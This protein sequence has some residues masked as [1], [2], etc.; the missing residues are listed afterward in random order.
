MDVADF[1]KNPLPSY[2]LLDKL[3][4]E[5]KQIFLLG[6]TRDS[7]TLIDN[8]FSKVISHKVISGN[9]TAT[10]SDH[11]PRF[12]FIPNVFQTH[13]AKNQVFMK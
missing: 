11:L 7:K 1:N 13:L 3:S 12:L 2:P 10:I 9:I 8:I 6:L 5:K 4:R